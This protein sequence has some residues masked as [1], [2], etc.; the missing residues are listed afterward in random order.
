MADDELPG[1]KA[2]TP[3]NPAYLKNP[4]A[5]LKDLRA[6]Q[7]VHHDGEAGSFILTKYAD[8]RSILTD[9]NMWRDPLKAEEAAVFARQSRGQTK[10]GK[11]RAVSS[12]MFLDDPDHA[13]IRGPLA[14]ALYARVARFRPEVE[15]IVADALDRIGS[16]KQF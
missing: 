3:R 6:R 16:Q 10:D 15:R 12:I 5:V 1:L 14:Q 2:M 4:Y 8:A 9:R 7:P 11:A 13:R